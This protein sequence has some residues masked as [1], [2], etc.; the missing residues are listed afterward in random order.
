[1]RLVVWSFQI[2]SDIAGFEPSASSLHR[3]HKHMYVSFW[4]TVSEFIGL[5]EEAIL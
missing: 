5:Q 2:Y 1:M 4:Q 3:F